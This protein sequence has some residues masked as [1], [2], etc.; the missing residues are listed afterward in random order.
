MGGEIKWRVQAKWFGGFGWRAEELAM[1]CAAAA[2]CEAENLLQALATGDY[3][4]SLK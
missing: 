3:V 4:C 1:R 2:P